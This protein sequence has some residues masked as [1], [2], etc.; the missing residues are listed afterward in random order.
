WPPIQIETLADNIGS[1]MNALVDRG[2]PRDFLDIRAIVQQ[3]LMAASQCWDFWARK[4][5]GQDL[6]A[7]KQKVLLHLDALEAR[8]PL[9]SI[10]SPDERRH[11]QATREWFRR[12]FLRT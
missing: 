2:A 4:N 7:A 5:S 6:T 11:M 9:E 8:R 10:K 1:K 12:D 3:G